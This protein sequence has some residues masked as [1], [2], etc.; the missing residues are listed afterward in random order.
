MAREH[1]EIHRIGGLYVPATVHDDDPDQPGR[2]TYWPIGY[3][4]DA[5]ALAAVRRVEAGGFVPPGV[6][7][8]MNTG[9]RIA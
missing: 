5:E 9:R 2:I 6:R 7:V 4:T 1:D 3:P 8:D